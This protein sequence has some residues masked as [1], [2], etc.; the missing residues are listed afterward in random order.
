[1]TRGK[2]P[3]LSIEDLQARLQNQ[4]DTAVEYDRL[5][6]N[7]SA[8]RMMLSPAAIT[9]MFIM[10]GDGMWNNDPQPQ[11]FIDYGRKPE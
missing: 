3:E 1:M 7:W 9:L 2:R 5:V 8:L 10:L 6:T 4:I 11:I